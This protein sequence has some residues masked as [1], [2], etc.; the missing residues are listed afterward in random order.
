MRPLILITNDDGGSAPGI[1]S[2]I[3]FMK[4]I[5]EVVVV[6]P[7]TPQSG[8]AH[9]ITVRHP[10]RLYKINSEKHHIEY[11][12][13]GT[14]VDCVKLALDKIL[15]RKPDLLVSG[16]NHG[17]NSSINVIYSGTVS[18]AVEGAILNIP[19][20]AFSVLE[21]T[22]DIDFEP[23]K[24]YIIDIAK[25]VLNNGLPERICLNVNIP[26]IKASEIKGIRAC[27]QAI[28]YWAEEFE[29]RTDPSHMDYYWI[30]GIYKNCDAGEDTDEW[31][32]RNN[33]ISIVPITTDFTMHQAIQNIKN[34]NLNV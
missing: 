25:N 7:T 30:K 23:Y 12:C 17:S 27:R 21:Y 13:S 34:W 9:S 16:I 10:L 15:T 6:A 20:I 2:L 11:H 1:K 32:L 22:F 18:A 28:G 31:A 5:G 26:F 24:K 4:E 14:P 33:Y 3:S 8:M 19:S 29:K